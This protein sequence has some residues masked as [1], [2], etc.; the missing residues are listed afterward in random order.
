MIFNDSCITVLQL[1][2]AFI[3]LLTFSI[4]NTQRLTCNLCSTTGA[5]VTLLNHKLSYICFQGSATKMTN[6]TCADRSLFVI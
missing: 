2:A 3:H 6:Q 5:N 4:L 1:C